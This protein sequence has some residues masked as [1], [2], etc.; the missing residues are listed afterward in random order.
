MRSN[1]SS[2][3]LAA[4]QDVSTTITIMD[5]KKDSTGNSYYVTDTNHTDHGTVSAS[6]VDERH[7]EGA[8]YLFYD[9][10]VKWLKQTQ[11]S[12]WTIADD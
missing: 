9:G 12:M 3:P 10:H 2:P 7:L 5:G 1:G 6:R 8:N 11:P 4:V